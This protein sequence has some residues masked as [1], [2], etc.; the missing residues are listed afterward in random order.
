MGTVKA[1]ATHP[2]APKLEAKLREAEEIFRRDTYN[3][4]KPKRSELA[5][6][7]RSPAY[8]LGDRVLAYKDDEPGTILCADTR[9]PAT[10]SSSW[11]S[12][13]E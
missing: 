6:A 11:T 7:K 12:R 9:T 5:W 3:R 4:D 2:A 8:K 13:P 1:T 10:G